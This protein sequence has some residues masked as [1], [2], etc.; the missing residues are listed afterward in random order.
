MV[1][2]AELLS[3]GRTMV[4]VMTAY[5][6]KTEDQEVLCCDVSDVSLHAFNYFGR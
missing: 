6:G 4:L 1:E 5:S 3:S 2:A